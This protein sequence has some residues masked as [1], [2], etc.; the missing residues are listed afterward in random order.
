[1]T[2]KAAFNAEE[3][4]TLTTAPA[5]TAMGVAMADRGG[6][7]RESVS[8]ARAY[9]AARRDESSELVREVVSAPPAIDPS[10]LQAPDGVSRVAADRL[11]E[12]VT[13]L[14]D[15]AT[16]EELADYRRFVIAVAETVA[17]A[18]R[19]GGFL[20]VGGRDVSDREQA[21]LDDIRAT[22]GVAAG[23]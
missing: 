19:E 10:G 2:T 23:G 13:L 18:H 12:A 5:L 9:T 6:T 1:M 4:S 8:M 22:L 3:W 17:G 16:P 11:R 15:K 21:A 14:E 20:G 7:L